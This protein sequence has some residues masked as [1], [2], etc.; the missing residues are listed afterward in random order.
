MC[1]LYLAE[2]NTKMRKRRTYLHITWVSSLKYRMV[3]IKDRII[4]LLLLSSTK[5]ALFYVSEL[6]IM[7][8]C[9]WGSHRPELLPHQVL[10]H[11]YLFSIFQFHSA[12]ILFCTSKTSFLRPSQPKQFHDSV[13]FQVLHFLLVSDSL[14]PRLFAVSSSVSKTQNPRHLYLELFSCH[15]RKL[16]ESAAYWDHLRGFNPLLVL[17]QAFA[18][19]WEQCFH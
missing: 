19:L 6:E 5:I 4:T 16:P 17:V 9:K 12:H 2:S 10:L 7:K 1:L 15:L 11:L 13:I 18:D 14:T 3:I 8:A